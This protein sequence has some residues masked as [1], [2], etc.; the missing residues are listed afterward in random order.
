MAQKQKCVEMVLGVFGK[1][2]YDKGLTNKNI[3]TIETLA[4]IKTLKLNVKG[5]KVETVQVD[6]GEPI[7]EPS[8]IPVLSN[9]EIVKNLE[10]KVLDK[11]FKFTCVSM[12]NPHAITYIEDI[13]NF[14]IEKYGP[15]IEIDGYFP[16]KTNVEFIEKLDNTHLKMRV[17]ERGSGETLACGTGACASVV[18]SI[19]NGVTE[20]K[21]TVELLGGNLEIEWNKEDNHVYMT[22]PAVTVFEGELENE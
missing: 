2:V 5:E 9:E 8:K 13:E 4:G 20:R 19:L 10:I 22:G 1:F 18:A 7:L 12:G 3:V 21:V 16:K 17:W 15:L 11:S 14:E 6:M